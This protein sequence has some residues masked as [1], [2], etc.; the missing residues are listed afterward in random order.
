MINPD[1]DLDSS[2]RVSLPV[3]V[4]NT[5]YAILSELPAR[6]VMDLLLAIRHEAEIITHPEEAADTGDTPTPQ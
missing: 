4:V 3:G 1:T 2:D 6:Q 5:A